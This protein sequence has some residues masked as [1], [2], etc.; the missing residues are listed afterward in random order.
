[1]GRPARTNS[2]R[3]D[4]GRY[5]VAVSLEERFEG[6]RKHICNYRVGVATD[7]P[8]LRVGTQVLSGHR[9]DGRRR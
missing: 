4:V 1:M 2:Q 3:R 9:E 5:L 8:P 6:Y 7:A